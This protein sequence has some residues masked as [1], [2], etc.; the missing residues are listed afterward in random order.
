[1]RTILF[2]WEL[3]RGLGH[4]MNIRRIAARLKKRDLRFVAAV[5]DLPA[6]VLL[7]GAVSD[8]IGAPS[9][10]IHALAASKRPATSS[11]SLNDILSAAG[12]ADQSVVHRLLVAWDDIFKQIR[13]DLVIADFSPLAALA[14]YRRIPLVQIGNGYTLPPYEMKR[15]P[16]LHRLS[17]PVWNEEETLAVVNK[18]MQ[19]FGWPPLEH[20]PRV[21]SGDACL[22]QT[23]PLLDPY[24]T[25]RTELLDGPIFDRAPVQRSA[26]ASSVLAYLSSG[27]EPHPLIVEALIPFAARLRVYAPRLSV[28]QAEHL[29]RAGA[30]IDA[31]PLP[32]ADALSSTRLLIHSGGSGAAAEALAAGVPQLVL[33]AHVEQ[34]L[35]GEALQRAGVAKLVRTYEPGANIS[36]ELI[37]ALMTDEA[38]GA[39]AAELGKWHRNYLQTTDALSQ[40]ERT[41]MHLL[42]L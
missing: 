21:F 18:A 4:V 26:E 23:F 17:R 37:R 27:Y 16:L 42:A 40:C 36:P 41:C 1:M 19:P 22:V 14:A 20:L 5:N 8:I 33:S 38:L 15:F 12:L 28:A 34:D 11:A 13:P 32:L 24:D 25:Q 29:R 7:Q 35:N 3:G 31:E 6:A 30:Q 39:R 9:W 2:A 10:P